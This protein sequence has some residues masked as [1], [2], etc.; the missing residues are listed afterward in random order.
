MALSDI[1]NKIKQDTNI[2][3][4]NIISEAKSQAMQIIKEAEARA[5]KERDEILFSGKKEA[6][7]LKRAFITPFKLESKKKILE[8]KRKILDLIFEGK[9]KDLKE[10]KE[11]EVAKVLF[12]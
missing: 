4:E 1:E 10:K 3:A 5:E 11:I 2:E 8:E 9:S 12:S 7:D 6:E